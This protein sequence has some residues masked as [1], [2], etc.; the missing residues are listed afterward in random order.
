MMD[1]RIFNIN[2]KGES[3]LLRVLELA[4][5]QNGGPEHPSKIKGWKVTD[6]DGMIL[7]WHPENVTP[8][9]GDGVTAKEFMPIVW[10]WLSN[11][12]EKVKIKLTSWD[13]DADHDGHNG[14]G[15]RVY[16]GDWG[17]V[18]GSSY[19]ICA[20]KPVYLWYGK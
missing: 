16:C 7:Y 15:W 11:D 8:L 4:C 3:M 2:G 12:K 20:V 18:G 10:S 19:A 1:N 6:E 13:R 17:H 5:I 9:P 14:Q